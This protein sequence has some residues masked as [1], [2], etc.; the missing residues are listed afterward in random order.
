MKN[1]K[2]YHK[3]FSLY[4]GIMLMIIVS[5]QLIDVYFRDE[6]SE[7]TVGRIVSTFIYLIVGA[8]VLTLVEVRT[9]KTK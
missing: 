1:I 4:C 3:L 2:A 9:K 7:F 8:F 5:Q 6:G